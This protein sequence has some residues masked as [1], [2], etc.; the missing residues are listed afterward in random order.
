[1]AEKNFKV[2]LTLDEAN[3]VRESLRKHRDE[4]ILDI[5]P[6]DESEQAKSDRYKIGV[7]DTLLRRDFG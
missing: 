2:S 5:K 3:Q 6:T 1:M 4:L 7:I